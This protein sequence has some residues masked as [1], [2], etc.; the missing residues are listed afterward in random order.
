VF[1]LDESLHWKPAVDP[2]HFDKPQ[3][4]GV[5]IGKS[6]AIAYADA[7]PGV[8][9]GLIPC[10]VGGT[11]IKVWAPSAFHKQTKTHPWDDGLVRIQAALKDG[12]LK[13]I[14]WHQ[15]ESDTNQYSAPKYE[16]RLTEL[17][18][19]YRSTFH[20]PDVPFIIGQLGQFKERPWNK[21]R[22][23]VDAAQKNVCEKDS[24]CGFVS[25]DNLV[26]GGDN[27][28]FSSSSVREFGRRYYHAYSLLTENQLVH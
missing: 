26:H 10:A 13:G 28:H 18:Q 16:Q 8:N 27:A 5:G 22:T 11:S 24:A 19:R 3:V 25:S 20:A 2:L 1:V 9:V 17:I 14:L 21:Y 4:D 12:E 6:F 7:N 15:G 23:M